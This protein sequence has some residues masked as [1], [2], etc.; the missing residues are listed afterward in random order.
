MQKAVRCSSRSILQRA[1][2]KS[3]GGKP[4]LIYKPLCSFFVSDNPFTPDDLVC[5]SCLI[6]HILSGT[7]SN[8]PLLLFCHTEY[9]QYI[10]YS[11]MG[12]SPSTDSHTPVQDKSQRRTK[13][14]CILVH[15]GKFSERFQR[16]QKLMV[17]RGEKE[18][19]FFS[20]GMSEG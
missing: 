4:C 7:C 19:C 13:G 14:A 11:H 12:T 9:I 5:A 17:R 16:N 15:C 18:A 8:K 6:F 20:F 2:T 3:I 10:L 1:L